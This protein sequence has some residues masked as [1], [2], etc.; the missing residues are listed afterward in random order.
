M[1]LISQAALN[2]NPLYEALVFAAR[3]IHGDAA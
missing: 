3:V 1:G 2:F